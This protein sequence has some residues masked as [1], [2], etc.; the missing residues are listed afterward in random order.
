[1]IRPPPTAPPNFASFIVPLKLNKLDMR[2]YLWNVY[3]V[4]CTSVRSYIQMQK[5]RND[6][7]GAKR[8]V[9]KKYRPRSIKKMLVELDKPF[10]FPKEMEDLSL[11]VF[12]FLFLELGLRGLWDNGRP[13]GEWEEE[14]VLE[15][16][17]GLV[18]VG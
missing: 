12:L 2:D 10:V 4:S 16:R 15:I 11:Y 9:W 17:M 6:K 7:K 1:M 3:G 8:P 14:S 13:W 5:L 18:G